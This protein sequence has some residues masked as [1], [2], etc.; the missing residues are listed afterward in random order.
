MWSYLSYD[1]HI[2]LWRALLDIM[3]FYASFR[4]FWAIT[5]FSFFLFW[6][7]RSLFELNALKLLS[8]GSSLSNLLGLQII[9]CYQLF[10]LFLYY[11]FLSIFVLAFNFPLYPFSCLQ[12]KEFLSVFDTQ[13]HLL[14]VVS[15]IFSCFSFSLVI[16]HRLYDQAT[17]M[18]LYILYRGV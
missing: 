6:D 14:Q 17:F 8:L 11:L 9:D 2:L 7:F 15:K 4:R 16:F 10:R 12:L 5:L 18:A 13:Q 1:K 3:P